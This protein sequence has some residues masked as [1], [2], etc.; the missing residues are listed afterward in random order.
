MGKLDGKV[1]IICSREPKDYTG[2]LL[3]DEVVLR[4]AGVRNLSKYTIIRE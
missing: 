1:A 4:E 2:H 3:F